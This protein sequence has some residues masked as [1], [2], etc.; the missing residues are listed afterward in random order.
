[1]TSILLVDDDAEIREMLADML[2]S[3]GFAIR[4]AAN[5]R[6]ALVELRDRER[7]LPAMIVLDL[8][9]PVMNGWEFREQQLSDP[10]LQGIPVVVVSA[11]A[12][13]AN[14]LGCRAVLQKPVRLSALIAAVA[15]C[16]VT[17]EMSTGDRPTS[18]DHRRV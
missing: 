1:V 9:M 14:G 11:I 13:Q 7:E 18:P 3:Q 16:R 6:D 2:R 4:T 17:S 10:D 15:A 5:G 12:S 8:M